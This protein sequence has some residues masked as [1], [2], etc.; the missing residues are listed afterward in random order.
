M[1][2]TG[3]FVCFYVGKHLNMENLHTYKWIFHFKNVFIGWQSTL[4]LKKVLLINYSTSLSR[5][6]YIYSN[7]ADQVIIF[8]D[9][10]VVNSSFSF[11][12]DIWHSI[13]L[14]SLFLCQTFYVIYVLH[15]NDV[16]ALKPWGF[17]GWYLFSTDT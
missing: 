5:P 14:P 7:W 17:L 2:H 15:D 8:E 13:L 1:W 11:S 10:G 9:I 4:R 16:S 3:K 12:K 6:L